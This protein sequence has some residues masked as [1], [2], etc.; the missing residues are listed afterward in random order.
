[1][2]RKAV[3]N[4]EDSLDRLGGGSG[5]GSGMGDTDDWNPHSILSLL[6]TLFLPGTSHAYDPSYSGDRQQEDE[7]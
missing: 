2:C 4:A 6:S 1:L 5:D 3:E 7:V